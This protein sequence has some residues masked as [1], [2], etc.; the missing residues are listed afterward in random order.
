MNPS[1]HHKIPNFK[2]AWKKAWG[3]DPKTPPRNFMFRA[4]G[5]PSIRG[6]GAPYLLKVVSEGET[7]V[8]DDANS[9]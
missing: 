6:G 8:R 9:V 1:P 4:R 2:L 5:N 7:E 3:R